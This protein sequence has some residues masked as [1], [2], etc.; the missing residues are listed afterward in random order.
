MHWRGMVV[1][2]LLSCEPVLMGRFLRFLYVPGHIVFHFVYKMKSKMHGIN[3][4][5]SSLA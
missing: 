3:A 5:D 4:S 2:D 1:A